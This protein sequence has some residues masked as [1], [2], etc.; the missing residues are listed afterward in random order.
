MFYTLI[1]DDHGE[2][3]HFGAAIFCFEADSEHQ[4]N[5]RVEWFGIDLDQVSSIG[6]KTW[7][8]HGPS[9]STP[10]AMIGPH[11]TAEE[12]ALRY[13]INYVIVY[14]DDRIKSNIPEPP[15]QPDEDG[16]S[17]AV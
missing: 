1:Q 12:Y 3:I 10:V 17:L 14:R 11:Y 16:F 15:E 9:C 4:A 5:Q 8:W 13:G 7:R 2:G 6:W